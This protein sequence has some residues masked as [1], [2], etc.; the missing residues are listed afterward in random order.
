MGTAEMQTNTIANTSYRYLYGHFIK[1]FIHKTSNSTH[2][3]NVFEYGL[4][5]R[6]LQNFCV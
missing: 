5:M 1:L 4:I 6:E 3:Q 2:H